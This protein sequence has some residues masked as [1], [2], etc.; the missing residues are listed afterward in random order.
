MRAGLLRHHSQYPRRW[1]PMDCPFRPSHPRAFSPTNQP[2]LAQFAPPGKLRVSSASVVRHITVSGS[3]LHSAFI[4]QSGSKEYGVWIA[5]SGVSCHIAHDRTILHNVRTPPPGCET[6]MIGDRRKI[7]V[8]YIGNMDVIFHGKTD[9]MVKLV[10]VAYVPG[11][12][13]NLYSLR[14]VQRTH[15]IVSDASGTHIIGKSLT[16]P[17]SSG[18]S[19]LR[20]AWLP[21]RTLGARRRQGYMRATNFLRQSQHPVPPPPQEIPPQKTCV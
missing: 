8:E 13:F 5:D 4:V 15:L 11:L 7:E 18:R 16:F 20:A 17:Q 21:P 10:D 14:A 6:I 9:Q 2:T 1:I 19:Y 3:H 12:G